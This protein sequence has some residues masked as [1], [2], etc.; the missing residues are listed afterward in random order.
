MKYKLSQQKQD[1]FKSFP[2]LFSFLASY[3]CM[4]IVKSLSISDHFLPP[5]FFDVTSFYFWGYL[6]HFKDFIIIFDTVCH[7]NTSLFFYPQKHFQATGKTLWKPLKSASQRIN[8][9]L[10]ILYFT[11][12]YT[13]VVRDVT[14]VIYIC[15]TLRPTFFHSVFPYFVFYFHPNDLK[16]NAVNAFVCWKK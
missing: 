5:L 7:G 15:Q 16:E 1:H 3:I 2:L 9:V 10:P 8:S 6:V 4:S 11:T 14:S 12:I 13:Y